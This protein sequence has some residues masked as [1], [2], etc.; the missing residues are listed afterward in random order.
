MKEK[1][2]KACLMV[3]EKEGWKAFTFAKAAEV[4]GI[5]LS[6]F[7]KY[8]PTPSD[9][10]IH[11]FQ[12][13]DKS[14]L[15]HHVP[16]EGLSPKDALFEILME[17]LDEAMPYKPV[18][19]RFWHEWV[20]SPDDFPSLACQGYTSMTWMLEA[21]G[22]NHRGILG[23]LRVQGL[24]ALYLLTLRTWLE[25]ETPDLGKTMAFL[26]KGLSTLEQMASWVN[27]N[28]P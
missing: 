17:R 10:M 4:S 6:V 22:L 9:V 11:L 16:S 13:I 12:K 19:K 2:F 23:F 8:F 1:A 21:V 28:L 7:N 3:I 25:D 15:E 27:D 24:T 5:P 26:D 14:V 20:L 18:L